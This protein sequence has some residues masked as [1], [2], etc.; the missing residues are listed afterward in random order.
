[1]NER[2]V[3]CQ[4]LVKELQ[5]N[6]QVAAASLTDHDA[7][8]LSVTDHAVKRRRFQAFHRYAHNTLRA[9][10]QRFSSESLR[11][12]AGYSP[13]AKWSQHRIYSDRA[14]GVPSMHEQ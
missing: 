1:M 8:K 11:R 5:N 2:L 4:K 9:E 12:L 3:V 13:L 7:P 14:F 6:W 10:R